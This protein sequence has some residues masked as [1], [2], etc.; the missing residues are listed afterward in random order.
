MTPTLEQLGLDRLDA[1]TRLAVAEALMESVASDAEAA[2]L[3]PAQA[4]ELDRR[5][6]DRIA[7]PDA[8]TPWEVIY[9]RSLARAR[10]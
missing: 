1:D 6:A 2:A 9:A 10:E 8:F 5:L 3:T 4:A 7:R